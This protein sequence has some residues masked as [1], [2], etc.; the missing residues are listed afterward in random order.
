MTTNLASPVSLW[1]ESENRC[2]CCYRK[3]RKVAALVYVDR[4]TG[5]Y[6][7]RDAAVTNPSGIQIRS[8]GPECVKNYGDT[9]PCYPV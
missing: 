2:D 5:R 9:S 8:V 6:T 7:D 3:L 1:N 4:A